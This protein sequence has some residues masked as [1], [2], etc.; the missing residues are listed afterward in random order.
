MAKLIDYGQDA[1]TK[2]LS[3]ANKLN[4]AVVV[5]MGAK[6]QNVLIEGIYEND[7][8]HIT[9]DGVTV[10][11]AIQLKDPVE[12]I[13]ANLIKK[14]A[15]ETNNTVGDGTT[16]SVCLA[17][18][19]LQYGAQAI[20]E[21]FN[22]VMLKRGIDIELKNTLEY[23]EASKT[24]LNGDM[25]M[26]YQVAL[27]SAN[28]DE[29]VATLVTDVYKEVGVEGNIAIEPDLNSPTS[30]Y[31]KVEGID[32]SRGFN[33]PYY[34]TDIPTETVEYV[35]P[36]F[37]IS[38][39]RIMSIYE[40]ENILKLAQKI[41][42]PI[43]LICEELDPEADN[44]I[45]LNKIKNGLPIVT[46]NAPEFGERRLSFLEDLATVTGGNF[47]S[48]VTGKTYDDVVE[49]D[50]GEATRVIVTRESTTIIGGKGDRDKIN[51]RVES[52]KTQIDATTKEEHQKY[53]EKRYAKLKGGVIVIK[54][55][56]N[57]D[58]ERVEIKDRVED[59]VN[60]VKSALKDGI[61]PGGGTVLLRISLVDLI[62]ADSERADVTRGRQVLKSALKIPFNQIMTNAGIIDH[63]L[64]SVV[65]VLLE[66]GE[67]LNTVYNVLTDEYV[68][69]IE[70]GIIDPVLVTKTA[71]INASSIAGTLI[72]T[73]CTISFDPNNG[74]ET[75]KM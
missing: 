5:T 55:G 31:E 33:N 43:V 54:I 67:D 75:L 48:T 51:E 39:Y 44:M 11:K 65:K 73:G 16:T 30:S 72:T 7:A 63:D 6:G 23:L 40:V 70:E 56:A 36:I 25:E 64:K 1:F 52:I 19:I 24:S 58:V 57:S 12:R 37:L 61:I 34:V 69:G 42:R 62:G 74:D 50:F 10:A 68:D 47:I 8:P 21:G 46:I 27:V 22:P 26:A 13:A 53:L 38:D 18:A 20:K 66:D 49:E 28:G 4:D 35:N 3:G 32:F 29:E 41:G 15:L 60:S 2:L 9:K 17:N 71:L 59:A 14:V 45:A